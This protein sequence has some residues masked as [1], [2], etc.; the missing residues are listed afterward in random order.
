MR[1]VLPLKYCRPA[2]DQTLPFGN[3]N[4][5]VRF[6]KTPQPHCF[7]CNKDNHLLC[8]W[9]RKSFSEERSDKIKTP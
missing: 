6:K 8:R 7:V 1:K 9:K 3:Y 5:V 4:V 2:G